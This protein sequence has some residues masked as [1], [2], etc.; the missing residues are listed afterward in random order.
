MEQ[1]DQKK[2]KNLSFLRVEKVLSLCEVS[3]INSLDKPC[4]A[5]EIFST[6]YTTKLRR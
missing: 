5:M 6:K 3:C 2:V 4:T 1:A